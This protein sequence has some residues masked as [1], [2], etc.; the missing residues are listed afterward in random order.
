MSS[1]SSLIDSRQGAAQAP[2]E[3]ESTHNSTTSQ[4]ERDAYQEQMRKMR[5]DMRKAELERK[6]IAEQV[7]K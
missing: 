5:E 4:L 7:L 1:L 2:T 3:S 6:R